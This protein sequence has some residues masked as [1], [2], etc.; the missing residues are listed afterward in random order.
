[1]IEQIV[2]R[3]L[4]EWLYKAAK[5]TYVMAYIVWQ[6]PLS[7][8]QPPQL[9]IPPLPSRIFQAICVYMLFVKNIFY[10]TPFCKHSIYIPGYS[11][12]LGEKERNTKNIFQFYF[13]ILTTPI[14]KLKIASK[15]K[16]W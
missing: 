1:M 4:Q 5:L 9:N 8:M 15:Q 2:S 16:Y 6:I 12:V 11:H 10:Y 13:V 3:I 14:M 7:I